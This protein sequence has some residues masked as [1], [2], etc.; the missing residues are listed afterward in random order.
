MEIDT[1]GE[2]V[3]R[4]E[5]DYIRGTTKI[6]KYVDFD[7]YETINTI[8]AYL[9]SKHISG[10][11]DTLG[12]EKPFF[13]IVVSASNI[14]YRATDIDRKNIKVKSTK[15][16]DDVNAFL[17]T[18]YLQYWM[19]KS[20]FAS[21]LN[22]W[23]RVLARYGSAVVKFSV[24]DG[25]LLCKVVPW[26]TLIVDQ[27]D[28]ENNLKIEV[29][30]M[31]EQQLRQKEGY[32]QEVVDDLINTKKARET[33]GRQKKDNK[34]N[35]FKVYEVHGNISKYYLTGNE[36]D[37]NVFVNQLH[38]LT[39][40][41]AKT[42]RKNDWKEYTLYK[43]QEE[44]PYMITHLIKEDGRTLSI[45]AVEHLFQAQWMQNHTAKSIKDQLD[46]ASKLIFQTADGAFVGQNALTSIETGDILIHEFNKPLTQI[47]NNSHDITSLQSFGE[48]WKRLGNEITGISESMLGV[49][50]KSGTAWRQTE[51]LLQESYSLFELMTENK[52]N[53]IEEMLRRF[54]IPYI[55]KYKLNN[56]DE[57]VATLEGHDL[58]KID[59]KFIKNWS[60]KES[61]KIIKNKILNAKTPEELPTQQEQQ[62]LIESMQ[63]S[64]N[65]DLKER[66][67]T[68]FVSPSE[69]DW[70]TQFKDIEWELEIDITGENKDR[71]AML[72]TYNTA[73]TTVMNPAYAQNKQAQMIVGKILRATGD[74][75]EMELASMP[76]PMQPTSTGEIPADM[77]NLLA[78]KA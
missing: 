3:T 28:F 14:W 12:R 2:L 77:G 42:D 56:S 61:N 40:L 7:M 36:N 75:S 9:N 20:G 57:I 17:A 44:D 6:S 51:A 19:T 67:N 4:A 74:L 68:R 15:S 48:Q 30:E 49:A 21:F 58:N 52:G 64:G 69:V 70:K 38:V 25:E 46:L 8:E 32:D 37:K 26:S 73:L 13:N 63:N 59:T 27:I 60:V 41:G 29:L 50:P 78:N 10:E 66:G 39:F 55:R 24:V 43:G 1:L 18:I 76:S 62:M 34:N 53:H 71:Q 31:T 16:K 45:G 65:S 47:N 72:A 11:Y 23:G 35:Y 5:N 54:V 22:D 33:I